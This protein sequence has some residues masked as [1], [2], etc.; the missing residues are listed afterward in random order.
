[1]KR[2]FVVVFMIV[3]LFPHAAQTKDWYVIDH[4][5][6]MVRRQP[7][8]MYKIVEQLPTDEKVRI[9]ETQEDWAKIS[10]GNGKTGWVLKRFL[11]EEIPKPI[12]IEQLEKKVNDLE[13]TIETLKK[14]TL[15]VKQ[16]YAEMGETIASQSVKMNDVS[17][18]NQR[19]KEEPYR[20]ILLLSGGGIFL[21]GCIVTLM[22]QGLGRG[23]RN[24][25][26]FEKGIRP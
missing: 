18:E 2:C 8:E 19:L 15:S 22:I 5:K 26:S 1:M 24:K 11:T 23:R 6:I 7:G 14:E 3:I 17:L 12:Q 20:I 9:I 25:L 10:F 21:I 4:F 16:K 13:E